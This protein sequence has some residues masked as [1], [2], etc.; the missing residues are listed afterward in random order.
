MHTTRT[1]ADR[2]RS[3]RP[4]SANRDA[5]Y[6]RPSRDETSVET[7]FDSRLP[8]A[9]VSPE[10]ALMYAVLEDA[11]LC[12]QQTGELPRLVQRRAREAERWFLSDDSRWVFS[13]R[14]I[15]DVLGLDP[16]YMRKKLKDWHP[17]AVDATQSKR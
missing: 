3:P 16:E 11:F 13:F 5:W 6:A 15:C 7:F 10:T 1:R 8:A 4:V 9:V 2:S 14:P 17:V 12:L